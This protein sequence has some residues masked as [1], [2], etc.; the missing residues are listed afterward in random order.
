MELSFSISHAY[1]VESS[2][3]DAVW[4][5]VVMY[6]SPEMYDILTKLGVERQTI[7]FFQKSHLRVSSLLESALTFILPCAIFKQPSNI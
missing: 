6:N 1:A 2:F 4:Q 3:Y 5:T 7:F